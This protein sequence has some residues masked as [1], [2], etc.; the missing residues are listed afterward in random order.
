MRESLRGSLFYII[1]KI[2]VRYRPIQ[3]QINL[4]VQ[5]IRN[6]IVQMNVENLQMNGGLQI[7]SVYLQL[8]SPKLQL[9]SANLQIKLPILQLKFTK[10]AIY[11]YISLEIDL[12]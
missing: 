8:K 7:K 9:K 3:L 4:K 6:L 5:Q 10:S 1:G 12:K 11:L 2:L